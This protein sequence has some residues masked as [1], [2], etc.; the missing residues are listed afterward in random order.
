MGTISRTAH[1]IIYPEGNDMLMRNILITLCSAALIAGCTPFGDGGLRKTG[2]NGV[3]GT[4]TAPGEVGQ[5]LDQHGPLLDA[6]TLAIVRMYGPTIKANA[7]RNGFDWRLVLATMKQESR[8]SPTAES[9]RGAY[10]LMQLMPGTSEEI[11]RT[12][13]VE[14]LSHPNNNIRGGIY[15]MRQLYDLFKGA[16]EADRI[17]LTLAAYNAGI[18]RIYDAQ[19][20]AAYLHEDPLAWDSI[21]DMLPLLSRRYDS[22][23]R[24]VW[25]GEKPKAGYFGNSRETVKYVENVMAHYDEY[26]LMLN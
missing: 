19:D 7:E 12:L 9:G 26:R 10:G 6:T 24:S 22:L 4:A 18:G 3:Q 21:K 5:A 23:H 20:L 15:Y 13:C 8:F 17:K 16:P 2:L 11:A 1:G 14:D 25:A